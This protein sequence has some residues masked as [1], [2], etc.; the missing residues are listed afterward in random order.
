MIIFLIFNNITGVVIGE[1]E[2]ENMEWAPVVGAVNKYRVDGIYFSRSVQTRKSV[3]ISM[4]IQ[5][6]VMN[7]QEVS[8]RVDRV[9]MGDIEG[10]PYLKQVLK[11]NHA[12][13]QLAGFSFVLMYR[14]ERHKDDRWRPKDLRPDDLPDGGEAVIGMTM[15]S[16]M[17]LI[18]PP[19]PKDFE[20]R[21]GFGW[22]DPENEDLTW[23]SGARI[24]RY[25]VTD[26]Y[27]TVAEI[28]GEQRYV[29][30]TNDFERVAHKIQ[31]FEYD[32]DNRMVRSAVMRRTLSQHQ[33]ETGI[34]HRM[35]M[36][37]ISI[38]QIPRE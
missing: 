4:E 28:K 36:D 20:A 37:M 17:P 25:T 19:L 13:E 7:A 5:V 35:E 15:E 12:Q 3:S 9:V 23:D 29:T 34:P 18:A 21:I 38:I 11:S 30:N 24:R 32:M 14:D 33:D 10:R 6:E 22:G 8:V 2:N 27:K 1:G 16:L 26:V 31:N